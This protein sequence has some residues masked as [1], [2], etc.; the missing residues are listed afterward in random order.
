M[1]TTVRGRGKRL[2]R[3]IIPGR[4]ISGAAHSGIRFLPRRRSHGHRTTGGSMSTRVAINGFGRIGRLVFRN[5]MEN[6]G[7]DLEVVAINDIAALDNLAYLLRHD[8]IQPR[9]SARIEV[10]DETLHW[11]DQAVEYLSVGRTE[12]YPRRQRRGTGLLRHHR[13]LALGAGGPPIDDDFR[14][15]HGEG[16]RLVRQRVGLRCPGR[17][18]RGLCRRAQPGSHPS[19]RRRSC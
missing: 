14:R 10:R 4:S 1:S 17:R 6:P 15:P 19:L 9:P 16:A 8:S 3:R 11:N 18:V 13:Q 12:R 2:R 7:S 5:L